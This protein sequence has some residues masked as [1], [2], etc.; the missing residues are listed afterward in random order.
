MFDF[1]DNVLIKGNNFCSQFGSSDSAFMCVNCKFK[2]FIENKGI[3]C[4]TQKLQTDP[5]LHTTV[6]TPSYKSGSDSQQLLSQCP[7]QTLT[8]LKHG[9]KI[10]QINFIVMLKLEFYILKCVKYYVLC[11][12][13]FQTK[14]KIVD[15]ALIHFLYFLSDTLCSNT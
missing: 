8:L 3:A 9:L 11:V 5:K 14:M 10:S 6:L 4:P 2:L 1:H 12:A 13:A 15:D 7:H